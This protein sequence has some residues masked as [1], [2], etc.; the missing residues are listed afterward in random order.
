[1][2]QLSAVN[3]VLDAFN[4]VTLD[5]EQSAA[6]IE[7]VQCVRNDPRTAST[8]VLE[9]CDALLAAL[10]AAQT[11]STRNELVSEL[12]VEPTAQHGVA[13]VESDAAMRREFGALLLAWQ[14]TALR[15]EPVHDDLAALAASLTR[16]PALSRRSAA[17]KHVLQLLD[18]HC[19]ALLHDARMAATRGE[20][21]SERVREQ[22]LVLMRLLTADA[23]QHGCESDTGMRTDELSLLERRC[24]W[25]AMELAAQLVATLTQSS[26]RAPLGVVHVLRLGAALTPTLVHDARRLAALL[27]NTD[28]L[29]DDDENDALQRW[30]RHCVLLHDVHLLLHPGTAARRV[31]R[32]SLLDSAGSR[33]RNVS[34]LRIGRRTARTALHYL[35]DDLTHGVRRVATAM[36]RWLQPVAEQ[37]AAA[38]LLTT[39]LRCWCA[40]PMSVQCAP[41]RVGARAVFGRVVS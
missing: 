30:R 23:Q 39:L 19:V 38:S 26:V 41:W 18:A 17:R 2:L 35:L 14:P 15:S 16:G 4:T 13:F 6:T 25:R 12:A 31:V 32:A 33:P 37:P 10:R 27:D 7:A 21:A 40:L 1:M 24:G 22:S 8:T 28:L 11:K 9:R 29:D 20:L 36:A 5:A 3:A 34:S